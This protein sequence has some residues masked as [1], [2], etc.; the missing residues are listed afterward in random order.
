VAGIPCLGKTQPILFN[1][2][3]AM[4]GTEQPLVNG[5]KLCL[6][7]QKNQILYDRFVKLLVFCF[8]AVEEQ[9]R[10]NEQGQVGDN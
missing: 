10:I 5:A 1:L 3:K 9:E 4:P 6:V 8:L 7:S 2:G